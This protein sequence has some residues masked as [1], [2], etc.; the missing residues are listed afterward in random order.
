MRVD[1]VTGMLSVAVICLLAISMIR[2]AGQSSS[3]IGLGV[4]DAAATGSSRMN[5]GGGERSHSPAGHQNEK[6]FIVQ[7]E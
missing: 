2:Q 3:T 1:R 7:G 5:G 6:R 4:V